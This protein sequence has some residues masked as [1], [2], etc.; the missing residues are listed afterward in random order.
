MYSFSDAISLFTTRYSPVIQIVRESFYFNNLRI[1]CIMF[2]KVG[3]KLFIKTCVDSC[4][5]II[6]TLR[7][8]RQHS[9][10]DKVVNQ[11]NPVFG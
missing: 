2:L 6:W 10:I 11:N 4:L 1:L 5:N 7:Q 8:H 9:I 3:Q